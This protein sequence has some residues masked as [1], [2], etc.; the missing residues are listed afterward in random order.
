MTNSN[1]I[2]IPIIRILVIAL[3]AILIDHSDVFAQLKQRE[4]EL[5]KERTIRGNRFKIFNNYLNFGT[6]LGR[7]IEQSTIWHPTAIEYNFHIK[8]SYFLIG[9]QRTDVSGILNKPKRNRMNDLH[10]CYGFRKETKALNIAYYGGISRPWGVM[11]DSLAFQTYGI[12]AEAQFIRKLFYDVGAGIS[13]FGH[14]NNYFP[15]FGIR[16]DIFLSG[17]YQGK[18]NA[19]SE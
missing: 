11:N 5:K 17:A 1:R 16:I 3:S 12:Y 4:D 14:Y 6:G 9:Y 10:L 2:F 19:D 8:R 18:M 15:L 13:I 7:A